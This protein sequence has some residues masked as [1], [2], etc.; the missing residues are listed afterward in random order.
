MTNKEEIKILACTGCGN[1]VKAK[2]QETG[3][4]M[5]PICNGTTFKAVSVPEKIKCIY[6]KRMF[7]IEEILKMY[8]DIPFY[9]D[10]TKT[11]YCGCRGW[12]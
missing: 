9:D 12:D 10:T 6:C 11:F 3:Q 1:T 7:T 5:C 2:C 4:Y 8:V